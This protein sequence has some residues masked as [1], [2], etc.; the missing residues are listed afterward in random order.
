MAIEVRV[1]SNNGVT[2]NAQGRVKANETGLSKGNV[3]LASSCDYDGKVYARRYSKDYREV[4]SEQCL[5][6]GD[7]NLVLGNLIK[8]NSY[9]FVPN[10]RKCEVHYAGVS[11]N[12]VADTNYNLVELVKVLTPTSGVLEPFFN[13]V[14]NKLNVYNSN[15]SVHFKLNLIG[16]WHGSNTHKS[17]Q[18]DFLGTIGNRLL[19]NRPEGVS[20]DTL[21]LI[22]LLSIDVN[23]NIASNGTAIS[24]RSN[25][26]DYLVTDILLIAEQNSILDEINVR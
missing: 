18:V 12:L 19:V 13:P 14:S 11:V 24:I 5:L 23:G 6:D 2:G 15:E 25:G 26:G 20:G 1:M 16:S 7:G 4:I 8:G 22:G 9:C 21:S 10:R 3:E 17:I